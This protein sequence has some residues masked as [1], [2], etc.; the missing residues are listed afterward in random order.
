MHIG[1]VLLTALGTAVGLM[2]V[3]WL[4]YRA[5]DKA[6]WVDAFWAG[7][8][9]VLALGYAWLLPG[10]PARRSLVAIVGGLWGAR[11]AVH[12]AVR[13]ANG[14]EDPRYLTLRA[15]WKDNVPLRFL[16]FFQATRDASVAPGSGARCGIRT[17]SSSGCYGARSR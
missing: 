11:L 5:T 7:N 17:T 8:L 10:D 3:A 14:P 16:R 4:L 13:V 15:E 1:T 12:I 2:F 9:A 6:S